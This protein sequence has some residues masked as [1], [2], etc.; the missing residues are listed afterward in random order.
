[1]KDSTTWL[2]TSFL[3]G[4]V[5]DGLVAVAMFSEMVVGH[6][7]PL[8]HSVP[9]IPYRYAIGL[10]GSLMLGWTVLLLWANRKPIERR[11]VL[12]LTCLVV[13]GLMLTV[14]FAMSSTYMPVVP[15]MSVLVFQAGLIALF[16][17]SYFASRRQHP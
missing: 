2:R 7:S 13:L 14:V 9:D 1:M 15:G 17:S 16:A 4:A 3:V 8:T 5:A 6:A 10:A 12:L 11:G